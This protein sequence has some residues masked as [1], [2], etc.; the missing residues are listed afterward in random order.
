VSACRS[1]NAPVVWAITSKT[2]AAIPLDPNPIADGNVVRIGTATR[3]A[4]LVLVLTD[5]ELGRARKQGVVQLYRSHFASCPDA[6][7]WRH[8]RTKGVGL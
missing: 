8:P 7:R 4:P 2:G 3:G 5:E 1:C 6:D